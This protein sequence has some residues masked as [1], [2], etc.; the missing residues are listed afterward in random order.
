[1]NKEDYLK[2]LEKIAANQYDTEDEMPYT[3]EEAW[4][5]AESEAKSKLKNI[6][7]NGVIDCTKMRSNDIKT[8]I[9]KAKNIQ[10]GTFLIRISDYYGE[11]PL[12]EGKLSIEVYERLYRTPTGQPCNMDF[13]A[14]LTRD[15][16]FTGRPWLKYFQGSWAD[17]VPVENIIEIVRWMQALKKLAAFL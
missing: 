12:V 1:M 6:N 15:S 11:D 7:F 2:L 4:I 9:G 3:P 8:A 14:D 13:R 10:V 17:K 5:P 16:R